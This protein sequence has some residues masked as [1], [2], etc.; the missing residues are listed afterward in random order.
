MAASE[1]AAGQPGKAHTSALAVCPPE[2][3]WGFVQALRRKYDRAFER[4]PPHLNLLYP[5]VREEELGGVPARLAAALARVEPFD[6]TLAGVSVFEHKRSATVWL[7]PRDEDQA[8]LRELHAALLRELPDCDDTVREGLLT[9]HLTVAKVSSG[10]APKVRAEAEAALAAAGPPPTFRVDHVDILVRGAH[11]P[12][13]VL[14]RV[15]LGS[16]DAP[17]AFVPRETTPPYDAS[18]WP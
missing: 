5:F 8:R 1:Q 15:P 12:F 3:V 17:P 10:N 16:G 11:T 9:P 6:V 18:A 14:Y 4:W 13:R 7:A 2:Q